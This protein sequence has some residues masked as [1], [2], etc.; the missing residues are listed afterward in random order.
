MISK[1]RNIIDENSARI[2]HRSAQGVACHENAVLVH[3]NQ[4]NRADKRQVQQSNERG[5][6]QIR[7][8]RCV[9]ERVVV[10][11]VQ[12]ITG[13]VICSIKLESAVKPDTSVQCCEGSVCEIRECSHG[14]IDPFDCIVKNCIRKI[15]EVCSNGDAEARSSASCY[16]VIDES[17]IIGKCLHGNSVIVI[18]SICSNR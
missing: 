13:N 12:V 9:Q 7:Q 3:S 18:G 2:A 15:R 11:D 1:V 10:S 5:N 6:I 17:I 16:I 8:V 4:W 14:C